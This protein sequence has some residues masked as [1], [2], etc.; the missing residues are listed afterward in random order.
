M[1]QWNCFADQL[2]LLFSFQVLHDVYYQKSCQLL[3]VKGYIL[4]WNL[5]IVMFSLN[6]FYFNMIVNGY[7]KYDAPRDDER[8]SS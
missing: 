2:L 5:F 6:K 7:I 3:L 8:L 1:D 4:N